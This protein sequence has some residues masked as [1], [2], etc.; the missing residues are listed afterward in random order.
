MSND[1]Y[2]V[3]IVPH[4]DQRAQAITPKQAAAGAHAPKGAPASKRSGAEAPASKRRG[5]ST[6]TSKRRGAGAPASRT[7]ARGDVGGTDHRERTWSVAL[8]D[9]KYDV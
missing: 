7:V 5:P 1:N 9:E 2:Y 4:A 3:V 8:D 6:P